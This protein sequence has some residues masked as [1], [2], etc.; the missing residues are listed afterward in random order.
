MEIDIYQLKGLMVDAA[1]MGA[2]KALEECGLVKQD[3]S[4]KEAYRSY[5]RA[6]VDGWIKDKLLIQHPS[7]NGSNRM[8]L[9]KLDLDI[10]SRATK[11][12]TF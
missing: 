4:M 3:F 1:E 10:L 9:K 7:N 6:K 2:K 8:V 5:G 11:R 12:I